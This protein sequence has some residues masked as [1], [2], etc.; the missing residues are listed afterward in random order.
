[1][2][3]TWLKGKSARTDARRPLTGL[4]GGPYC[5]SMAMAIEHST[6][7]NES[8]A[9]AE[10]EAS[11]KTFSFLDV[12]TFLWLAITAI[13]TVAYFIPSLINARS[14][15]VSF[16]EELGRTPTDEDYFSSEA[17]RGAF[18][19]HGY[20]GEEVNA[21]FAN[22]IALS[23]GGFLTYSIGAVFAVNNLQRW[24]RTRSRKLLI[25]MVAVVAIQVGLMI[26]F[27]DTIDLATSL[28]D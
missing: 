8:D 26:G 25:A 15:L 12:A 23:L 18:C 22:M 20:R 7:A 2:R 21:T 3:A 24:K 27:L 14:V 16:A 13:W 10:P 1:M 5:C 6:V 4:L 19:G 11:T 28:G 9:V 17:L